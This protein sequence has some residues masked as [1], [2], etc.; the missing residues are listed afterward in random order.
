M[1]LIRPDIEALA[2]SQILEV[3]RM[4]FEVDGPVIGMWAG[5]PDV[6]TPAFICDAAARAMAE[7]HTFYAHNRGIAPVRE[8]LRGYYRRVC[9]IELPDSRVSLTSAGMNAVMLV[10]QMLIRPGDNVVAITPSWPN[11]CRAMQINRA[12]IREVPLM[13]GNAGWALDLDAVFE[14]CDEHTRMIYLASPG[15]P[16]GFEIERD[17]AIALLEFARARGIAIMSDEV[18]HRIV[19]DRAVSFSFLEIA[20]P[21]D[22]VF[23]IG[24]FSKSWAMT[25]WRLGWLVFPEGLAPQLEK[26]IQ[27][28]T[29]GAPEF[30]QYGAIAALNDGDAFTA[31]FVARC[32]AGREIV[33][34]RLDAMPRVHNVPN[35]GSFYAMFSIEGVSDT[36]TFCKRA[37]REARI[38]MAPGE[39]FGRGAEGMVR[40]CYAKSPDM[41]TEAMDRLERFVATYDGT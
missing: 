20:R 11:I 40:L 14:A 19:Y 30:L 22:A 41:L 36:L 38:G 28:N 37:V 1:S 10:S 5:E 18:Y 21:D 25:G 39:A 32:A 35:R 27:F 7:G 34:A 6:P 24:T 3:W 2:D 4:Q 29:S 33:N 16:T 23:V 13:H 26:L 17:D 15:N 12:E 9:G 31:E 8:A